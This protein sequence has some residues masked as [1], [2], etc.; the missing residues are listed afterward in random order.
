MESQKMWTIRLL[1]E[2]MYDFGRVISAPTLKQQCIVT[3]CTCCY[4]KYASRFVGAAISR[5]M[6]NG[7][8]HHILI[9]KAA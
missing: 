8:N 7:E 1:G 5:P 9:K 3:H 4:Q 2:T 6:K